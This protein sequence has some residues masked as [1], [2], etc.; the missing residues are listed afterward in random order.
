M[1]RYAFMLLP[2]HFGFSVMIFPFWVIVG[3]AQ[4]TR[5]PL[6]KDRTKRQRRAGLPRMSAARPI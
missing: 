5:D 6:M 1:L 4:R 2:E 3:D